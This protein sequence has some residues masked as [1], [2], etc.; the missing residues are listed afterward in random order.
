MERLPGGSEEGASASTPSGSHPEALGA[1]VL[2]RAKGALLV[3]EG[4]EVQLQERKGNGDN[5][6]VPQ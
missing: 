2:Q 3:I 6:W 5:V 4:G 1:L